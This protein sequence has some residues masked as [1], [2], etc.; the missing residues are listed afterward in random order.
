M[1]ML[2]AA[3]SGAAIAG[4]FVVMHAD[5][6]WF[7]PKPVEMFSAAASNVTLAAGQ[8]LVIA[9]VPNDKRLVVT[10]AAIDD[11]G[12]GATLIEIEE[13]DAT[14]AIVVKLPAGLVYRSASPGYPCN[15]EVGAT[16]HGDGIGAVFG[17]GTNVVLK[18]VDTAVVNSAR[19]SYFVGGYLAS[20]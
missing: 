13:V 8:S 7:G 14:G 6:P 10:G 4:F 11:F 17:P 2:A 9:T 3:A 18:N 19:M 12:S 5:T 16:G 1:K 20:K 15:N